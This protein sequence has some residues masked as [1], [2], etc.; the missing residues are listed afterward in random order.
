MNNNIFIFE[1]SNAER[2]RHIDN[3]N[4]NKNIIKLV[5]GHR[6]LVLN[7]AKNF[8]NGKKML[9]KLLTVMLND[10]DSFDNDKK[11][12]KTST[13]RLLYPCTRTRF[14]E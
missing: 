1:H 5:K 4:K 10:A 14:I 9:L 7:A 3:K 8:D 11:I 6:K 12:M 13:F 2:C